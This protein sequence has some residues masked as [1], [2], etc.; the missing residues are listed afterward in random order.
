MTDSIESWIKGAFEKAYPGND[1]SSVRVLPA[2]DAKF[3]VALY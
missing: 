3:G 2:T 1:F